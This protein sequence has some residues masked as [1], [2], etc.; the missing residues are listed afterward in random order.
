[1]NRVERGF[2]ANADNYGNMPGNYNR[3]HGYYGEYRRDDEH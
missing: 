2:H 1:M 3:G